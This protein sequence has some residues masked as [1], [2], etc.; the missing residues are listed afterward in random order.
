MKLLPMLF[1]LVL[2]PVARAEAPSVAEARVYLDC[3]V[4]GATHR[5]GFVIDRKA[6][7]FSVAVA[8]APPT[9]PLFEDDNFIGARVTHNGSVV[10]SMLVNKHTLRY[11]NRLA[12][13]SELDSGG[14]CQIADRKL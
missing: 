1:V 13:F 9:V 8:G 11:T 14:L 3:S 6:G 5:V 12:G 7:L 4:D 10:M 2:L